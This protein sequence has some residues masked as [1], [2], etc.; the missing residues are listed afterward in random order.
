MLSEFKKV[1]S[2]GYISTRCA[3][4]NNVVLVRWTALTLAPQCG[5]LRIRVWLP[6][7]AAYFSIHG[8]L[9]AVKIGLA[10][11]EERKTHRIWTWGGARSSNPMS[12]PFLPL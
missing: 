8:K 4:G 3:C 6:K 10:E 2:E 12:F 9:M 1:K 7:A 11:W 5:S